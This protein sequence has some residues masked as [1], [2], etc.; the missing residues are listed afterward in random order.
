M[1]WPYEIISID[2]YIILYG[3]RCPVALEYRKPEYIVV[4]FP[5]M[6]IVM[7]FYCT[8]ILNVRQPAL[9]NVLY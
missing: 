7:C 2:F 6:K 5:D 3:L 8:A 4:N 9:Q 1:G